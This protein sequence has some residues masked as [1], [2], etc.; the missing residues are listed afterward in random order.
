MLVNLCVPSCKF[1]C[2]MCTL[3]RMLSKGKEKQEDLRVREEELNNHIN[4][5]ELRI[6]ELES[7][8]NKWKLSKLEISSMYKTKKY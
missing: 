2:T 8:L 5:H 1:S 7:K 6:P 4:Q 3:L